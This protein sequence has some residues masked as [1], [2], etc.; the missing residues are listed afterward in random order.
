[1]FAVV[2]KGFESSPEKT[3][4]GMAQEKS[5]ARGGLDADMQLKH[6]SDDMALSH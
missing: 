4:F 3:L 5:G 2:Y 6:I 1:M